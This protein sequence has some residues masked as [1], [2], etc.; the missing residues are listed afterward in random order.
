MKSAAVFALLLAPAG[1]LNTQRDASSGGA[2]AAEDLAS[3]A[4]LHNKLADLCV[5]MCKE[6]G[7]YPEKCT[8]PNYVDTTDKTPGVLTWDE[9]L[10]YMGDLK[11]WGRDS[12]KTWKKKI[13]STIQQRQVLHATHASAACLAQDTRHRAAVQNKLVDACIDMCKEL[14]AYPEKCTCPN[15]VDTT[16]KTPGVITWEELLAY[17]EKVGTRGDE[18]LKSW[19]SKA[20]R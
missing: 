13:M 20:P 4:M 19:D 10:K 7:A 2:C 12:L 17:M 5:D 14:G 3:R 1:A 18:A 8:C 6:V 15:Y 16:D 9:L 11:S